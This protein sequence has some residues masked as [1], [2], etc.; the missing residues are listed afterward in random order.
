MT[1]SLRETILSTQ[2]RNLSSILE[3]AVSHL[4][5]NIE[6]AARQGERVIKLPIEDLSGYNCEKIRKTEGYKKLL[7]FCAD[8]AID[9]CVTL[10][11]TWVN[12]SWEFPGGLGG[13]QVHV[14]RGVFSI[15]ME[16]PFDTST[17]ASKK[18]SPPVVVPRRKLL[19]LFY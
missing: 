16:R 3:E 1:E 2:V 7:E 19:G 15:D 4:R 17:D 12:F 8:P 10:Q 9:M 11:Q 18:P 5:E 6:K 13:R 14:L